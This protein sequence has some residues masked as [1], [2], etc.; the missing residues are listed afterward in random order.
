MKVTVIEGVYDIRLLN[1][2]N[3][4]TYVILPQ[5]KLIYRSDKQNNIMI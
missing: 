1:G 2:L 4:N 5:F 3:N